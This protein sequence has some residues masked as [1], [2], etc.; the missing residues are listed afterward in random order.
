MSHV[1]FVIWQL[2]SSGY[3]SVSEKEWGPR[4]MRTG[5]I[6]PGWG[7]RVCEEEER[8]D[9]YCGQ[10]ESHRE[11][12]RESI[13]CGSVEE[14]LCSTNAVWSSFRL[15]VVNVWLQMRSTETNYTDSLRMISC[16]VN[17]RVQQQ[18]P[19]QDF[20]FSE[21]APVHRQRALVGGVLWC[22]F[23]SRH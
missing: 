21:G 2:P 5:V 20:L 12:E 22:Y 9:S 13:C 7:R 6:S 4:V 8:E 18:A 10:R 17:L 15:S 19:R 23:E 3:S 11:R 16:R 1:S 14:L